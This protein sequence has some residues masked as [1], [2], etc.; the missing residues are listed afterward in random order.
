[1]APTPTPVPRIAPAPTQKF[2]YNFGGLQASWA[3]LEVGTTGTVPRTTGLEQHL[4]FSSVLCSAAPHWFLCR[5]LG[6]QSIELQLWW[7]ELLL[8]RAEARLPLCPRRV[9]LLLPVQ[10]ISLTGLQLQLRMNLLL[11]VAGLRKRNDVLPQLHFTHSVLVH[12]GGLVAAAQRLVLLSITPSP[13]RRGPVFSSVPPFAPQE[14]VRDETP[15]LDIPG[16]IRAAVMVRLDAIKR[17]DEDA[18][19]NA[20][21]RRDE[22]PPQVCPESHRVRSSRHISSS[23]RHALP[24]HQVQIMGLISGLFDNLRRELLFVMRQEMRRLESKMGH[25]YG[26]T[27]ESS[28][29]PLIDRVLGEQVS[30]RGWKIARAGVGLQRTNDESLCL[31]L[32]YFYHISTTSV[33]SAI[34]CLTPSREPESPHGA[35]TPERAHLCYGVVEATVRDA[36]ALPFKLYQLNHQVEVLYAN[37]G[38]AALAVPR[39]DYKAYAQYFRGWLNEPMCSKYYP[40]LAKLRADGMLFLFGM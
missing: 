19:L 20:I 39:K 12:R 32:D 9:T 40:H 3:E 1:M 26:S 31:E 14:F 5:I 18:R 16:R 10:R 23:A 29:N 30:F 7:A 6:P 21:K 4:R 8:A 17:R 25:F 13:S 38:A 36:K 33:R 35:P 15:F 27:F 2:Q 24:A 22:G 34:T 37:V 11:R 28:L